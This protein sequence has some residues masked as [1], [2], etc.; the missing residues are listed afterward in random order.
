M[1]TVTVEVTQDDIDKA[2]M[3]SVDSCMV[4]RALRRVTTEDLAVGV[5]FAYIGREPTKLR[6]VVSLPEE[7]KNKIVARLN[8]YPV[9]PFSF[10][11][12]LPEHLAK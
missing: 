6:E 8:T 4:A 5:G 3:R 1:K 9:D 11:L 7:V 12:E 10:T 2:D